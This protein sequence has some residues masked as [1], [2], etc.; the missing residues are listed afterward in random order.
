MLRVGGP[1]V[2]LMCDV[3]KVDGKMAYM[4]YA[5]GGMVGQMRG[6]VVLF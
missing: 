4:G 3:D 5:D 1:L 6:V 2:G